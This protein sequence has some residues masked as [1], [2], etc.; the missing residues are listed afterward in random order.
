MLGRL[1]QPAE[2]FVKLINR[3]IHPG[4]KHGDGARVFFCLDEAVNLVVG[5][6][7][8]MHLAVRRVMRLLTHL[9]IW[10]FLLSTNTPLFYL[11][12]PA[13]YNKSARIA[14]GELERLS[15]FYALPMDVEA[16]ELLSNDFHQA[17]FIS[18]HG[19]STVQHL[20]SFGR[21]LWYAYRN[22]S[23]RNLRQFV[24]Q[25]LIGTTPYQPEDVNHVLA[26]LSSRI[27]LEPVLYKLETIR[28]QER[29]IANHLRLIT[30]MNIVDGVVRTTVPPEPLVSEAVANLLSSSAPAWP[31]SI[32]TLA[33]RLL[34]PGLIDKGRSGELIT[35]LLFVLSRDH[36]L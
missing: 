24:L 2:R 20:T 31:V 10:L 27:C 5:T 23:C 11:A 36:C 6:D 8:Q 14:S 17:A 15:P 35:R 19:L 1:I 22:Y 3:G 30:D 33:T 4:T 21:P 26:A 12:P 13:R 29:G 16:S 7:D 28:L 32:H 34:Q 18:L 9:P 25:K